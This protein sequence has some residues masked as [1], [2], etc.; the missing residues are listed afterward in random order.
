MSP[1]SIRRAKGVFERG[2]GLTPA[3]SGPPRPR[4][5]CKLARCGAALSRPSNAWSGQSW[6]RERT[7]QI[8]A[9]R[10]PPAVVES[11]SHAEEAQSPTA[12]SRRRRRLPGRA[13]AQP[14]R[15]LAGVLADSPGGISRDLWLSTGLLVASAVV[16]LAQPASPD[17]MPCHGIPPQPNSGGSQ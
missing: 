9:V 6:L 12:A 15:L 8:W 7:S 13:R 11:P 10:G 14:R 4:R 2:C 16:A 3:L 5:R 17:H 1:A